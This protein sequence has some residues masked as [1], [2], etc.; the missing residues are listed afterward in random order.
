[1]PLTLNARTASLAVSLSLVTRHA[2]A[3]TWGDDSW[4]SAF[5][6]L[7]G[8][9]E[10]IPALPAAFIIALTLASGLLGLRRLRKRSDKDCR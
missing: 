8:T 7:A 6:G 10:G 3:F 9:V 4:G 5:W 1:M 2:N